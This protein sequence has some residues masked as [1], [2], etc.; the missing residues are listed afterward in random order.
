M[1]LTDMFN[2]NK[3]KTKKKMCLLCESIYMKFKYRQNYSIPSEPR[4]WSP[5]WRAAVPGRGHEDASCLARNG[6]Y[7]DVGSGN[8]GALIKF[9]KVYTK[10]YLLYCM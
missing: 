10:D 6:P 4:Q 2:K 5:S 8:T 7:F 3:T 9:I 1:N